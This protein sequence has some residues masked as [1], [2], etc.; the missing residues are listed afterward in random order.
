M[1]RRFR[2][3]YRGCLIVFNVLKA[4]WLRHFPCCAYIDGAVKPVGPVG[5]VGPGSPVPPWGPMGPAGPVGPSGPGIPWGP[6]GPIGPVGPGM[7]VGIGGQGGTG[8]QG[9][10]TQGRRS[11]W[12]L[13]R[14][15]AHSPV[16]YPPRGGIQYSDTRHSP[17][18]SIWQSGCLAVFSASYPMSSPRPPCPA[19]RAPRLPNGRRGVPSYCVYDWE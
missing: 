6:V 8:W 1:L 9:E 18:Q 19:S 14:F 5:P 7:G 10:H 12:A 13:M 15:M 16:E 17:F 2:C 11:G 4:A 3:N